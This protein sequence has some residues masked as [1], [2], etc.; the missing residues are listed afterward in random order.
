LPLFCSPMRLISSS[1]VKKNERSQRRKAENMVGEEGMRRGNKRGKGSRLLR[2][3]DPLDLAAT[4]HTR[5]AAYHC[6]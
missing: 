1:R 2:S 3:Y 6:R 4:R 5:L